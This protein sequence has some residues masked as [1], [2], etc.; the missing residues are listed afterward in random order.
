MSAPWGVEFDQDIFGFIKDDII[1][2][3]S[4]DD[5]DS[6]VC[7]VRNFFR[8][9]VSFNR[10][11]QDTVDE[12]GDVSD[13]HT[14][15]GW[16]VFGHIFLHIDNTHGWAVIVGDSEEFHNSFV[17]FD[18]TVDQDE[19]EFALEFFGRL[20]VCS[21][22]G[23]EISTRFGGKEQVVLFKITTEDFWGSLVGKFV[24]EGELFCFDESNKGFFISTIE[25]SSFVIELNSSFESKGLEF[26]S[27]QKNIQRTKEIQTPNWGPQYHV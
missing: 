20:G 17:I 13:G 22:N 1:E 3:L 25:V 19:K 8:F 9:Q 4:D 12:T 27:Q 18:I 7:I 11:V 26:K 21:K 16:G 2:V 5:L 15:G 14:I 24:N 23:V 6:V 10:S